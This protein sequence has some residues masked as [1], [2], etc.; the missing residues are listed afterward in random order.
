MIVPIMHWSCREIMKTDL[1][2]CMRLNICKYR[3][4]FLD[5][6][7]PLG[8][9]WPVRYANLQWHNYRLVWYYKIHIQFGL[10]QFAAFLKKNI[11]RINISTNVL[12]NARLYILQD[13]TDTAFFH[14]VIVKQSSHWDS[15]RYSRLESARTLQGGY[16]KTISY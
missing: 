12:L 8:I 5:I 1:K 16:T 7:Q 11:H 13:A 9:F 14:T 6:A 2:S 3:I 15:L 4:Y 10:H